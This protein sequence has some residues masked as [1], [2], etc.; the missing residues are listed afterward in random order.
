[1]ITMK[2]IQ[3]LKTKQYRISMLII[4][5]FACWF[6]PN[7]SWAS[8]SVLATGSCGDNLTYT[9]YSD[10]SMVISGTGEMWGYSNY[11]NFGLH[12]NDDYYQ[13]IEKVIIEDGVTTLGGSA[14]RGCT[15]L[16]SI[17]IP[18]SVTSF[19]VFAFEDCT[20]LASI[21]I[22]NSVTELGISGTFSMCPLEARQPTKA[23]STGTNL[24]TSLSMEE[25]R[26]PTSPP[27]ITLST[28]SRRMDVLVE[29][30][31]SR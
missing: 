23:L 14:F 27:S 30:W 29:R 20:S 8:T 18:N 11:G 31:T 10:M 19:G 7:N 9:I 13:S 4:G 26:T 21:E 5:M 3:S 24:N 28:W 22:P 12:I 2:T 1:M 25:N 6:L 15:S 16:T 17:D